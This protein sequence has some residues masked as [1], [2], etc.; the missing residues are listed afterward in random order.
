M[1]QTLDF[2]LISVSQ[3]WTFGQVVSLVSCSH[4]SRAT[5]AL[6]IAVRE[7]VFGCP[8]GFCLYVRFIH[9]FIYLVGKQVRLPVLSALA[10]GMK[11][12]NL[13]LLC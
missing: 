1:S 11:V 10:N 2:R 6:A 8:H 7:I 9:L 12:Y 4:D 13:K 3:T 5:F